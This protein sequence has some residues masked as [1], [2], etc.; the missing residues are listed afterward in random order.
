MAAPAQC[1]LPPAARR[2]RTL[3]VA[4]RIPSRAV[5]LSELV[6]AGVHVSP[7]ALQLPEQ[8]NIVEFDAEMALKLPDRVL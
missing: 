6:L 4:G 7:C 5:T 1:A 2:I 3:L 8:L